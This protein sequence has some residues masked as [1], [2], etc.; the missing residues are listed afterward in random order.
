MGLFLGS[1]YFN[2]NYLEIRQQIA[3]E[4]THSYESN[5][6][7]QLSGLYDET[8]KSNIGRLL[9]KRVVSSGLF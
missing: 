8:V 2:C 1:Q 4:N 3:Y 7:E 9:Y 5:F 6:P